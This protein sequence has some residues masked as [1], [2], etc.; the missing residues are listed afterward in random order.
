MKDNHLY[1]GF[2]EFCLDKRDPSRGGVEGFDTPFSFT[3]DELSQQKGISVS[4]EKIKEVLDRMSLDEVYVP[5]SDGHVKETIVSDYDIDDNG[6]I[7]VRGSTSQK[8][9]AYG[10]KFEDFL[11]TRSKHTSSTSMLQPI[12]VPDGTNWED[13]IIKM[14]GTEQIS[15]AFTNDEDDRTFHRSYV[16]AGFADQQ[17]THQSRKIEAW[18]YLVLLAEQ[19]VDGVGRFNVPSQRKKMDSLKN[20]ISTLNNRLGLLLPGISRDRRNNPVFYD[21]D[22]REYRTRFRISPSQENVIE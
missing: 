10:R 1:V 12:D 2:I 17:R 11:S 22:R 5:V 16:Q 19:S 3:L 9:D 6:V 14:K 8:L 7:T 21:I 13:V 20:H 15:V 4:V 18:N